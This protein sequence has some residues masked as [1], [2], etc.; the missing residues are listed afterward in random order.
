MQVRTDM[1]DGIGDL[2]WKAFISDANHIAMG[3]CV[4]RDTM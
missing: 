2:W 4:E 3:C 1:L